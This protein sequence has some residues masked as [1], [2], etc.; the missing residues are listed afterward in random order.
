MRMTGVAIDSVSALYCFRDR[1]EVSAYLERHGE[2]LPVLV[3]A[4][5]H[6]QSLFGS[7]SCSH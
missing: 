3:E 5:H 1:D 2:I 6:I 4:H 7:G